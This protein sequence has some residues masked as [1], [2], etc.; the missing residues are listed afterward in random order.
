MTPDTMNKH[1]RDKNTIE[2]KTDSDATEF[3]QEFITKP[4]RDF[5]ILERKAKSKELAKDE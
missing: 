1:I 4:T 3:Q 2:I 5:T